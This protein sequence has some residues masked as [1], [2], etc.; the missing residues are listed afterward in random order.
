[1]LNGILSLFSSFIHLILGISTPQSY[2]PPLSDKE[3]ELLFIKKEKGDAAAREKLVL[4][5]L[6]L[7]SHIVKKYYSGAKNQEDL[8]SIGTVGLIKAVD[9]FKRS[10]GARFATYASKCIENEILMYIRKHSQTRCEVSLD[11]P[12]NV[13]WDGNELLLCRL[14]IF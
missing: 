14:C 4:H 12:L 6:R 13:D 3:E 9:T 5:N 11:E 8:T 7:V 2:P 1:M 10:G